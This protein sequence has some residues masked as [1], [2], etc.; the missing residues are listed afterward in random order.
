MRQSSANRYVMLDVWSKLDRTKV[1]ETPTKMDGLDERG[2]M[3]PNPPLSSS[4]VWE[5]VK[6]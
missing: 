3:E 5:L 4:R 6:S 2:M 1:N